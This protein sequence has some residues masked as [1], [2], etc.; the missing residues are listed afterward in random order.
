MIN[1]T[2]IFYL[3]VVILFTP[4]AVF[5]NEN[6]KSRLEAILRSVGRPRLIYPDNKVIDLAAK[7]ALKFQW[8]LTTSTL[9]TLDYIEF[10]LYKGEVI[11]ERDLVFKKQLANNEYSLEVDSALFEDGQS[12]IW[13]IRQFFLRGDG[14]NE[15]FIL[16]K[17][18]K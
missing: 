6:G 8:A 15:N 3:L 14:S 9:V 16:F 18:Y 7:K 11:H 5:S 4:V 10:Y 12:Y 13:G 17:A 2:L 1:K